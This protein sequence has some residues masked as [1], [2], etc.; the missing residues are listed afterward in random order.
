[1]GSIFD[2]FVGDC[3]DSL[4]AATECDVTVQI[5]NKS[6]ATKITTLYNRNYFVRSLSFL[7]RSAHLGRT[8]M[9]RDCLGTAK[10]L[11]CKPPYCQC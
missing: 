10:N 5:K 4:V 7:S 11:S 2:S 9:E 1:M 8:N 3:W 6:T